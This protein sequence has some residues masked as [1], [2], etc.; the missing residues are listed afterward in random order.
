MHLIIATRL[1]L[2]VD[3]SV[4]ARGMEFHFSRS[5]LVSIVNME[6]LLQI[7]SIVYS[8]YN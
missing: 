5:A 3:R 4:E 1:E 8:R 7:F 6:K 2:I